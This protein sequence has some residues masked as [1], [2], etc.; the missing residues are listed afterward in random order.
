MT[1][2]LE[3]VDFAGAVV[4]RIPCR[5]LAAGSTVTFGE[6]EYVVYRVE[7]AGR[8]VVQPRVDATMALIDHRSGMT[9]GAVPLPAR[10]PSKDDTIEH[11]GHR[12]ISRIVFAGRSPFGQ[13]L[14][15]AYVVPAG[16]EAHAFLGDESGAALIDYALVTALFSMA[17]IAGLQ[18][19]S[20]TLANTLSGTSATLTTM[21]SH[22]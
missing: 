12:Y 9:I 8:I 11:A 7:R 3:L 5:P 21:A 13:H 1:A 10:L 4:G 17:M 19:V 18:L 20:H 22:P 6:A 14:A 16:T 15:T 2:T